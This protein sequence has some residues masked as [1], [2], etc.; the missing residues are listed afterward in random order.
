MSLLLDKT[1]LNYVDASIPSA[2]QE[3]LPFTIIVYITKTLNNIPI[4]VFV[5]HQFFLEFSFRL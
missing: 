1:C 5:W 4:S 3:S 2:I